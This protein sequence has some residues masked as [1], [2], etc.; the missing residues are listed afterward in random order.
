MWC[1]MIHEKQERQFCA[2][3]SV[4]NLLQ[5][6]KDFDRVAGI[7]V[8]QLDEISQQQHVIDEWTCHGRLLY[9]QQ[10]SKGKKSP[11][12]IANQ[13]K[14]HW[15]VVATQ[16][17]FNAIAEE[18][19]NREL[20]LM[21][22]DGSSAFNTENESASTLS[23]IQRFRSKH[24]SPQFGNY[25]FEV[26]ETALIRRGV[27]LEYYRVKADKGDGTSNILSDQ[28]KNIIG[29]IVHEEETSAESF[30]YLRRLGCNIPL[31]RNICK[32]GRHWWAITGVKRSCYLSDASSETRV[33][34]K[35]QR[36]DR[37]QWHLI[38]SNLD[39]ILTMSS[40]DDLMSTLSDVQSRGALV[41][42]CCV[43][44]Q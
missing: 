7:G 16:S 35:E 22:G 26:L 11:T 37:K 36:E 3:H 42:C 6:S 14:M 41:F 13:N 23:T 19:T 2:I 12:I 34:V 18:I 30:S 9:C 8:G 31:I 33:H 32:G 27:T 1:A 20:R 10:R 4:N 40:D 25:S 17:E 38:D 44:Q 29:F 15:N 21:E 39:H 5:L 28:K 43:A 24:F